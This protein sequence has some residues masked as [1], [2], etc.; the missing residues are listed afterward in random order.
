VLDFRVLVRLGPTVSS[1]L[2]GDNGNG[3]V[4]MRGDRS[5]EGLSFSKAKSVEFESGRLMG[6]P[7]FNEFGMGSSEG[8][9][10]SMMA[11]RTA[12]LEWLLDCFFNRLSRIGKAGELEYMDCAETLRAWPII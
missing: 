2:A 12:A 7:G 4:D 5:K 3:P 8:L 10:M 6:P 11:G 1:L 9:E